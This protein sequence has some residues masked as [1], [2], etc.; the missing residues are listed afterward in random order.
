MGTTMRILSIAFI[1]S[2]VTAIGFGSKF[3]DNGGVEKVEHVVGIGST[4]CFDVG[5]VE[6]VEHVV[7]KCGEMEGSSDWSQGHHGGW[8]VGG[9]A[10]DGVE[11]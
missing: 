11:V 10:E 5:G 7:I 9:G 3:F 1:S 2:I 8:D 4:K 6:E